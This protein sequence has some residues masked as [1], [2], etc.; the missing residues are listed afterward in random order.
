M[1]A[2]TYQAS[3]SKAEGEICLIRNMK[4]PTQ[5]KASG[6]LHF[7]EPRKRSG[8][9]ERSQRLLAGPGSG[10]GALSPWVRLAPLAPRQGAGLHS[11]LLT[12]YG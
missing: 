3:Y 1:P 5:P 4:A 10:A 6:A 7:A 11:R 9:A 8:G 12:R 2:Q